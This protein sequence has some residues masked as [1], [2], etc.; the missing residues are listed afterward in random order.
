MVRAMRAMGV[1]Y[2]AEY[3]Q[4]FGFPAQNIVHTESLAL[5]SASFTPMQVARG[6]AVMANGGFLIDPYFI[7]KIEN[8]QGGVIFEAKP[9][10]ACP[11]CDIPVIYGNTQKSDVLENTNVEE[12]AVSQEQ[13]NSAVPMPELEQANQG[14]GRAKR[15]AGVRAACDQYTAGVSDQKRAEHQYLRR[16]RLDGYRLACGARP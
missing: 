1:D 3:L 13:Q 10:I 7:S 8:D 6:Y 11:E 2:A 5:G 16:T 9:K 4:R 14:A 15:H 12:V